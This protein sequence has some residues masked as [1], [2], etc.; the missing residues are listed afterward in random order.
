MISYQPDDFTAIDSINER[1]TSSKTT[2]QQKEKNMSQHACKILTDKGT[3]YVAY[4]TVIGQ[5][6]S[7]AFGSL[8]NVSGALGRTAPESE[9]DEN[10][11]DV[12]REAIHR[13]VHQLS[14]LKKGESLVSKKACELGNFYDFLHATVAPHQYNYRQTKKAVVKD[15]VDELCLRDQNPEWSEWTDWE[16]LTDGTLYPVFQD[17][18]LKRK[19]GRVHQRERKRPTPEQN[20]IVGRYISRLAMIANIAGPGKSTPTEVIEKFYKKL[21]R[22]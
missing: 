4:D 11:Y 13:L 2:N 3:F 17:A 18:Q 6:V 1:T 8:E 15:W 14:R 16:I 21:M 22:S 19:F 5:F 7:L 12:R 9:A 10:T 20:K